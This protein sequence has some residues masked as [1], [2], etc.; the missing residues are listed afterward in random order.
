MIRPHRLARAVVRATW[1]SVLAFAALPVGAADR[2]TIEEEI[3]AANGKRWRA[4]Y[5]LVLTP[6]EA[7][8]E[9]RVRLIAGPGVRPVDLDR[10]KAD[11]PG[12]VNRYWNRRIEIVAG[13]GRLRPLQV[14]LSFDERRP[15]HVIAVKE[16]G[17][18]VHA[19]SW[20]LSPERETVIA[21]EFGHLIGAYDE[22]RGGGT[23]PGG[24]EMDPSGLMGVARGEAKAERR[25]FWHVIKSVSVRVGG[26]RGS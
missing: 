9:V 5:D 6:A 11:W 3:A 26:S 4:A 13:D 22:Y 25:H 10:V 8:V 1:A 16:G 12:I 23:A 7:A 14:R 17:R 19:R 21:H 15:H 18:G 24:S 2:L 20:P